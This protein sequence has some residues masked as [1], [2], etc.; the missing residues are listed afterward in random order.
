MNLAVTPVVDIDLVVIV[1]HDPEAFVFVRVHCHHVEELL[2]PATFLLAHV[3]DPRETLQN[4]HVHGRQEVRYQE[5]PG[6]LQRRDVQVAFLADHVCQKHHAAVLVD[7]PGSTAQKVSR[8][9]ASDSVYYV[10]V[11]TVE[12]S[13]QLFVTIECQ[14]EF[15]I[16]RYLLSETSYAH[17]LFQ[18]SRTLR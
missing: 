18:F 5:P 12:V 4:A 11:Q 6:P 16:F 15:A 3:S 10:F 7:S 1:A 9:L 8:K 2:L 14:K 13:T 17:I